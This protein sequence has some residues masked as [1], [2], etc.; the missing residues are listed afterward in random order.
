MEIDS[1]YSNYFPNAQLLTTYDNV[2]ST[3]RFNCHGYAWYMSELADPLSSPRWIG[4]TST[5]EDIYM[6]DGS[7]TQTSGE[8]Y[9]GKVSYASDDHSAITTNQPGWFISKWGQAILCRHRWDDT[10]Y[11][12]SSLKY[13]V[14]PVPPPLINGFGSYSY[15]VPGILPSTL[16]KAASGTITATPGQS[17]TVSERLDYT[18]TNP[19]TASYHI[20][21]TTIQGATFTDGSNLIYSSYAGP[22]NH[23]GTASKSFIMPANGSINWSGTMKISGATGGY[24]TSAYIRLE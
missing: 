20:M 5:Q 17:I 1:Y 2:S 24:V 13:Y 11:N 6:T 4:T 16:E 15:A 23:Y 12:E 14:K 21:E 7:Y 9:P 22:G 10:P 19:Q 3:R 8:R 18:V